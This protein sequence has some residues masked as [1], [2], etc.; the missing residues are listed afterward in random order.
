MVANMKFIASV[1][2]FQQKA[3]GRVCR[4]A[5]ESTDTRRERRGLARRSLGVGGCAEC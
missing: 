1:L 5:R 4:A 3:G 2:H